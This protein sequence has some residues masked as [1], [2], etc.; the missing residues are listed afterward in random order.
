[1]LKF[2]FNS[3]HLYKKKKAILIK[4]L[5]Y[6]L[7]NATLNYREPLRVHSVF[8]NL[9]AP[10]GLPMFRARSDLPILGAG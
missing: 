2:F 6:S 10:W 1:M 9:G 4:C 7:N 8:S 5:K 3:I